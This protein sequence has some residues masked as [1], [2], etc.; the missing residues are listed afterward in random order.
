MAA[1]ETDLGELQ[2]KIREL[3]RKEI[4]L[5]NEKVSDMLLTLEPSVNFVMIFTKLVVLTNAIWLLGLHLS[6]QA[7]PLKFLKMQNFFLVLNFFE[8]HRAVL[9]ILELHKKRGLLLSGNFN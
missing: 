2:T 3:G 8:K 4:E 6:K 5:R 7:R 1:K 9:K